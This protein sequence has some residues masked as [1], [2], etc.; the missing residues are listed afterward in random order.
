[1][2]QTTRADR[3]GKTYVLVHGAYHGGW[4]WQPVAERLRALGHRVATP[5]QT[6]LGERAHLLATHPTLDTFVADIV[7]VIEEEN[8]R[9]II[10][11]GHS[12][13]GAAVAGVTD[14]LPGLIRHLVFLDALV[15]QPNTA[16]AD[17]VPPAVFEQFRALAGSDGLA[18]PP[19]PPAY[20]GVSDPAQAQWL[21]PQLTPHPLSTFTS[22]L[23]L[24]HPLGNGRPVTYIACTDPCFKETAA[25]RD[26]ARQMPGWAY[27]EI[28]TGHDAMVSAPAELTRLLDEL[29]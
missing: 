21:A 23:H 7:Q 8:L 16:P 22:P 9:D 6:G 28:A 13:G 14:R 11:V 17:H 5:T 29:T 4:C 25:Y 20:F 3:D 24:D 27:L 10:L 15:L 1:M 2:P 18:V 26:Y 19:P 12:F